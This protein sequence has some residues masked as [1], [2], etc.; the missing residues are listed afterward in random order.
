MENL[1]C[2]K[3]SEPKQTD[4]N[5]CFK[6]GTQQKCKN[7]KADVISL[8]QNFCN[9][10]GDAI[11]LVVAT[12]SSQRNFVEYER[13]GQNVKLKADLTDNGSH[14][15][16]FVIASAIAGQSIPQKKLFGGQNTPTSNKLGLSSPS[17]I[18]A[19]GIEETPFT[20]INDEGVATGLEKILKMDDSGNLE[21]N[22]QRVKQKSKRDQQIRLTILLL[23]GYKL[24]QK[25]KVER[26]LINEAMTKI[27]LN[28]GNWRT[29]FGNETKL[30]IP[31]KET[32][33]LKPAG[34][35]EAKKILSEIIDE[36]YTPADKTR[37]GSVKKRKETD[38]STT[39]SGKPKNGRPTAIDMVQTLLDSKFFQEKKS[40]MEIEKYLKE[41]KGYAYS[42]SEIQNSLKRLLRDGKIKRETN[43]STNTYEYHTG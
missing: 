3:C 37:R 5:F 25:D 17:K 42:P 7:C 36:S 6:C 26:A 32:V 27:K 4:A 18:P 21:V 8:E 38:G 31:T 14:D 40:V 15:L 34:E 35:E 13:K 12:T 30:F 20:E 29:W 41:S 22:D 43:K 39:E 28:D 2:Y 1:T 11:K 16:S 19:S 9:Q 24:N 23:Y 10:C 33:E